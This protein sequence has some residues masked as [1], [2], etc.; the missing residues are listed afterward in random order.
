[1]QNTVLDKTVT[2][3]RPTYISGRLVGPNILYSLFY[4]LALRIISKPQKI[5]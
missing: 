5:G 3:T 2:E 4:L 1:M